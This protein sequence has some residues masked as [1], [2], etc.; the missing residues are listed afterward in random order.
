MS[1]ALVAI[2]TSVLVLSSMIL[3]A[4][5]VSLRLNPKEGNTYRNSIVSDIN[6]KIMGQDMKLHTA[7]DMQSDISK[8][9]ADNI[10]LNYKIT[11]FVNEMNI[12]NMPAVSYDS[13]DATHE[14]A[15]AQQ[16]AG[17]YSLIVN[18]DFPMEINTLGEITKQ[19]DFSAVGG[20]NA[21]QLEEIKESMQN[22]F[23]TFPERE[24]GV[25]DSWSEEKS[26]SGQ[27]PM[28]LKTTYTVKEINSKNI[29]IDMSG[30]ISPQD[31][32]TTIDGKTTG[33][34][35]L[36]RKTCWLVSGTTDM[37]MKVSITVQ[38]QSQSFDMQMKAV[39]K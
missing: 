1:V 7:M 22:I 18:K 3:P 27:V 28:N 31:S 16:M 9:A 34:M 15:M 24:L 13:N 25:G 12:P 14:G 39:I 4:S 30:S 17:V 21:P 35:N 32:N 10:G 5:K 29:I 19:P 33:T 37:D 23:L 26:L 11:R 36:D 38:G 20:A 8:V 6:M 2:C